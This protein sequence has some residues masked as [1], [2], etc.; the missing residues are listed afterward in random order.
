MSHAEGWSDRGR[1]RSG[2]AVAAVAL[3]L[4]V[5]IASLLY[6]VT[7]SDSTADDTTLKEAA[8]GGTGATGP[9][10]DG[11]RLDPN[12]I[13]EVIPPDGIPAI[14]EPS[15]IEPPE[16][17]WLTPREPVIA[18]EVAGEIRAYP[19]QILTWHEIVN[20][21]IA[22]KP[23]AVTFCPLCNTAIAFERPTIEGK[24]T[25]FGTSGKL[26][27]SNL[28]MYDR[29]TE[30]LWPQVTGVAL[31]GPMEGTELER[32]PAPIV[33]WDDFVLAHPDGLVLSRDTGH[34][35]RYGQNPY[36]G[37]DDVDSAP[38]L[39]SGDV[40]GRLAAV[41]RV[42]GTTVGGEPIAIPYFRLEESA[43]GGVAVAHVG[44]GDPPVVVFWKKGTVSA[45]DESDI[46]TSRDVGAA[47]AFSRDLNGSMLDFIV[48][49]GS[50]LDRQT[51]SKWNIFG[52]AVSGKLAGRQLRRVDATDSFWFDWAAFHPETE[53]W[54]P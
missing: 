17:D 8:A 7:R 53:V 42:L 31:T 52:K 16:A 28:L 45:L 29:A 54:T 34:D 9:G 51:R 18:V 15:F 4:V 32:I 23:I 33:A 35:R 24:V 48:Q 3:L 36:P 11:A 10:A 44:S 12:D 30:S 14:D 40:D 47:A 25:T 21:T 5:S 38:F 6:V 27:N 2:W 26:I 22:G 37:Y 13:V 50:I 20:D 19:L 41:E 43:T 1:T 39:Y 49:G 46:A